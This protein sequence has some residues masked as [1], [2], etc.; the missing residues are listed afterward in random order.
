M[1]INTPKEEEVRCAFRWSN[2]ED[3]ETTIEAGFA[4]Y[5]CCGKEG[6]INASNKSNTQRIWN[7][8]S[9]IIYAGEKRKLE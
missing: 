3:D 5:S 6:D 9:R 7:I 1:I 8:A 4:G 2:V